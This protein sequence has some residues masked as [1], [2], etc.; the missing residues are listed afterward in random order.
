MLKRQKRILALFFTSFFIMIGMAA[1]RSF[2]DEMVTWGPQE[3]NIEGS[4][5]YTVIGQYNAHFNNFKGRV[6][7]DANSRLIKSVYLRIEAGSIKSNHPWCDKLARSRRLLYTAKYPKIIFRSDKIMHDE[8][9]YKVKGIL[10]MHG[11]KRRM[12]FPFESKISID[13][14]THRKILDI[15][16][17]WNINRKDFNIIWNKYLDRGGVV[18][19]DVFTVNWGIK[20]YLK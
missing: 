10:E 6:V 14:I 2:A 19:S 11:I 15:R 12:F 17:S 16:G 5:K 1:G 3:A 7:L 9:G 20:T 18:V 13:Q 4:I 8:K